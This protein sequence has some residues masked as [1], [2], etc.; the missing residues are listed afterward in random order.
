MAFYT[1][2]H[3]IVG[4]ERLQLEIFGQRHKSVDDVR[5]EVR[6]DILW[7]EFCQARSVH[8]PVG[9]VTD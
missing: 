3:I 7:C 6:V 8:S 9:I 5:A 4:I 1:L 2:F